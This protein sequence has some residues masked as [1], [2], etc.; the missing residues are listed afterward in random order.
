MP[1]FRLPSEVVF[2][3]PRLAEE[4]GLLAVGGDL[5]PERL[6]TAYQHGIFPWYSVGEPILWFSPDPRMVLD[7]DKFRVS[8]SLSRLLASNKFELR[9]DTRFAD[10]IENCS[11]KPRPGQ[12]GTWITPE[13]KKAYRTLHELGFAH[14]FET[15][16]DG[17]L[18]GGLYGVSIGQAFFGESMYYHVR[19]ASKFAFAHLVAFARRYAFQFIDAQQPTPH[20]ASLGAE[21]MPRSAFL[22]RLSSAV[23][24]DTLRGPWTHCS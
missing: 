15:Y 16:Q 14:S 12:K 3:D 9:R 8:K 13:M 6:L 24:K 19:D 4:E 21:E 23:A 2:P 18:V 17:K 1:I 10:V 20:L 11:S 5:S 7:L 22:E